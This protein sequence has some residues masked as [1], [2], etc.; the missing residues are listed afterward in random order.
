ARETGALEVEGGRGGREDDHRDCGG[1]WVG[2][3]LFAEQQAVT[4]PQP[5][6][7]RDD[8]GL[9]GDREIEGDQAVWRED[10]APARP[11]EELLVYLARVAR[12]AGDEDQRTLFHVERSGAAYAVPGGSARRQ[13][14]VQ[15]HVHAL[16]RA[17]RVVFLTR[18]LLV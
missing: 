10:N 5:I 18:P 17:G 13:L 15:F 9:V 16:E 8:V 3:E 14:A 4:R 7:G 12:Q 11:E 2:V 1:S 6:A